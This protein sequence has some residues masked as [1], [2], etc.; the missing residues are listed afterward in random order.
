MRICVSKITGL[1]LSG[2]NAFRIKRGHKKLVQ[3]LWFWNLGNPAEFGWQLIL[4]GND[5]SQQPIAK[6]FF[7]KVTAVS[8][9]L[10]NVNYGPIVATL[11]IFI[12]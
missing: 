9:L 2:R 11:D 7:D 3:P 1:L 5:R 10:G 6:F 8:G 4:R 12:M